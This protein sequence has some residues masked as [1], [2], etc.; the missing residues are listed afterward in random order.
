MVLRNPDKRARYDQDGTIEDEPDREVTEIAQIISAAFQAALTAAHEPKFAD[1]V[2]LARQQLHDQIAQIKA[3]RS[4]SSKAVIRM[5]DAINRL[6]HK[7]D[8][9]DIV[10]NMLREQLRAAEKHVEQCDRG[11]RVHETAL[12]FAADYTWRKDEAPTQ[13]GWTFIATSATGT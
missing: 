1:V 12:E 13:T 2:E 8:R 6:G 3:A 11:I 4:Q 5:S 9:P 7:G 10:G